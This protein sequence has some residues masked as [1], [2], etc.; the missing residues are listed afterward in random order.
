MDEIRVGIWNGLIALYDRMRNSETIAIQ[1][2]AI[3]S[4]FYFPS[5]ANAAA[6]IQNYNLGTG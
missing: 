6:I 1:T 3:S 5:F 2:Y 4:Y